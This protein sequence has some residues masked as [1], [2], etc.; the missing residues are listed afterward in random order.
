[1]VRFSFFF[2]LAVLAAPAEMVFTH[3]GKVWDPLP[4]VTRMQE[5]GAT[6]RICVTNIE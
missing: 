1:M 6:V 2:L 5:S 3:N 4:S